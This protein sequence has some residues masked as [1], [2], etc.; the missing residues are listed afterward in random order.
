MAVDSQHTLLILHI[1]KQL[2]DRAEEL[3]NLQNSC[4]EATLKLSLKI[5]L[6][7]QEIYL[8]H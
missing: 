3:E 1:K 4:T 7:T 2:R 6:A 8:P 5:P